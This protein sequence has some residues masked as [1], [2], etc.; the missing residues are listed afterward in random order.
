VQIQILVKVL[1]WSLDGL[2]TI[3]NVVEKEEK[4]ASMPFMRKLTFDGEVSKVKKIA[5][6]KRQVLKLTRDRLK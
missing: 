1:L 4:D 6:L 3:G 5:K 2:S